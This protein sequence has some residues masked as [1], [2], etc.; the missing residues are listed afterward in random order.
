MIWLLV[1]EMRV[2]DM[3]LYGIGVGVGEGEA[4]GEGLG[5]ETK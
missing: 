2:T 4:E 3:E 5:V 1:G